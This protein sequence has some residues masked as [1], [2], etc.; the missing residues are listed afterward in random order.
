[1]KKINS[2]E[3]EILSGN[4]TKLSTDCLI[5][6]EY[7]NKT[8]ATALTQRL[9]YCG[10]EEGMK[11]FGGYLK[12]E[13]LFWGD[14]LSTTG[15]GNAKK[16]IHVVMLGGEKENTFE[17][18]QKSVLSVLFE[19]KQNGIQTLAFPISRND[20]KEFGYDS[21]KIVEM[22]LSAVCTYANSDGIIKE[23]AIVLDEG[24]PDYFKAQEIL[25]EYD[26]Q[27]SNDYVRDICDAVVL[28]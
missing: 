27:T 11:S 24:D 2:I 14:V 4:V 5:V 15:G 17:I 19:A 13:V 9:K 6:P 28:E 22:M 18:I 16:L 25:E 12:S 3:V 23:L 21:S 7:Y 26:F 8:Y 1:M 10:A 20:C